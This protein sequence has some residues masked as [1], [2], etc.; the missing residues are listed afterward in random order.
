MAR[1]FVAVIDN[2]GLLPESPLATSHCLDVYTK[3]FGDRQPGEPASAAATSHP[4]LSD[5]AAS[6]A[7]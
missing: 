5:P 1:P 4:L 2:R 6:A 3:G 7:Q